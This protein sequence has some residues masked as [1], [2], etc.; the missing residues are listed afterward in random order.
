MMHIN[1]SVYLSVKNMELLVPSELIQEI[2]DL[3]WQE[4]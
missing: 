2:T 1:A 3:R 4:L